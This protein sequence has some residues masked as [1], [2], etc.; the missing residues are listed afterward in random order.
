MTPGTQ[1]IGPIQ[2]KG[3][4]IAPLL[5]PEQVQEYIRASKAEN[6]LHGYS[7]D[8]RHFCTWCEPHMPVARDF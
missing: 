6:T 3:A 1:I 4:D 5:L 2:N 8:W 7:A